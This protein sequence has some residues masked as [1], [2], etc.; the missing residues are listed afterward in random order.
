MNDTASFETTWSNNTKQQQQKKK[1]N[2]KKTTTM[3][4]VAHKIESHYIC[5]FESRAQNGTEVIAVAVAVAKIAHNC[6]WREKAKD[7]AVAATE[8]ATAMGHTN[9]WYNL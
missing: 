1:K 6:E 7:A 3:K 9:W 5:R 2:R 8:V 4:C